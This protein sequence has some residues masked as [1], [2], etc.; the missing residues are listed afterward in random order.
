MR[1]AA[2]CSGGKDSSYA[3][4]LAM[5]QGH[6]VAH[7]VAMIPRRE[8]SWMFHFPNIKLIDLFAKC[9][10]LSLI[11]AETSGEREREPADLKR[12]LQGLNVEGVVSGA[13]ASSYQKNRIER[14]CDELGL[15]SITPLWGK[16]PAELLREMLVTGFKIIVTSAAAQ[17]LNQSWLGRELDEKAL[18]DLIELNKKYGVN[19]AG[20]GGEFETL[21]LDAPFFKNKI[22][23]MEAEP[24]WRGTSGYYL[25]K[26]AKIVGK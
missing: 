6:E 2:L 4:W 19:P 26:R 3:L 18:G 8:D 9:A 23:V 17:G 21:V 24:I 1:I 15:K 20:E 14:I 10:E 12:V 5:Q 13:I 16:D 25:I 7:I 11:K 22:E